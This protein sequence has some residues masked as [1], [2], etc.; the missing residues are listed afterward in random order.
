ME[1]FEQTRRETLDAW[2]RFLDGV[3]D[4]NHP[5]KE[6]L[7]EDLPEPVIVEARPEE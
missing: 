7:Q 3:W 1:N 4:D 6:I 5:P 2:D